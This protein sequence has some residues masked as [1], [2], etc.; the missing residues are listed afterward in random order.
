M[1]AC[2]RLG[3][4][5]A[6]PALGFA[7]CLA[8]GGGACEAEAQ[9][10]KYKDDNGHVHFTENLYEVPEKYRKRV[11]TR[12]MPAHRAEP[13]SPEAAAEAAAPAEGSV[14][15]SFEDGVRSGLGRDL[16]IKQQDALHLWMAKW[17]W[18]FIGA[19]LVN[20]LIALCLVIH[21]LVQG[22]ILWGLANFF[23]GVTSPFYL[24]IHLEQSPPVKAVLLLLYL[25]PIIVVAIAVSEL[26][27]TLS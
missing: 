6:L 17:K 24:V 11:E 18:P 2:K 23:V 19:L 27:S 26:V 7:L 3:L 21:A 25:S 5:L 14:A 13:G 1:N 8:L 22:H 15:A 12:D 9:A 20:C 10:Y 16:T 4:A